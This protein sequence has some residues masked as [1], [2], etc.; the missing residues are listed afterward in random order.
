MGAKNVSARPPKVASL[1]DV[2]V[3]LTAAKRPTPAKNALNCSANTKA[4]T[5]TDLFLPANA[6]LVIGLVGPVG[7]ELRK[8]AT[9]LEARL[10]SLHYSTSQ[11]HISTDVIPKIVAVDKKHDGSEFSRISSMMDAGNLAR[12]QSGDNSILALGAAAF[13]SSKREEDENGNKKFIPRRVHVIHSLK[14]PEEVA[15]LRNVYANGFFL[16]GVHADHERR[17]R[18]LREDKRIPDDQAKV[19]MERDQHEKESF[20]QKLRETFHLSDY[21]VRFQGHDDEL[22]NNIWRFLDILF[23]HPNKTPTF[24]EYAMFMAFSASLRSAD[25]SRQVGAVIAKND[26]V[27]S[28]G[29]NDCPKFGGGLYWPKFNQVTHDIEDEQDGRD[30]KRGEDSNRVEVEKIL[31]DIL[32]RGDKEGINRELLQRTLLGTRIED[33]TE[34]GRVVHAEME[35][36]LCCARNHISSRGSTLYCTTYPCHNC[37]K[38]IVASGIYRVVFIEPYPKSKAAVFHPDSIEAGPVDGGPNNKTVFESFVGV[39]PRRFF[40]LFS[41]RLGSGQVVNRK[42][43]NGKAAGWVIETA[44]LSELS[45]YSMAKSPRVIA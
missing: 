30:Y 23:G 37:A 19:L 4:A 10:T 26:E 45:T 9:I 3:D 7:T 11:V 1:P 25:L 34:F 8:V 44:T 6:E 36:I 22:K 15:R 14:H 32:D 13:I 17:L 16:I 5:P 27:L 39:G 12:K 33:L 2:A 31:K 41:V 20:G 42:L 21:F 38:H 29:A 18:Y 35:A 24:D 43:P 40:D 28:T